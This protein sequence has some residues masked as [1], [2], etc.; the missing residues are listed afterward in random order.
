MTQFLFA[1]AINLPLVFRLTGRSYEAA[2]ICAGIGGIAHGS[3]PTTTVNMTA[4][5]QQYGPSMR[6]YLIVLLISTLFLD[7]VN[8]LLIPF[9]MPMLQ[10]RLSRHW[11]GRRCFAGADRGAGCQGSLLLLVLP[12][13]LYSCIGEQLPVSF[14][15]RIAGCKQR[16]A[17]ED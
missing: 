3:T 16:V 11:S 1:P 9:F 6:A 17:I 2:V 13:C 7:L 12:V 14:H 10:W 8:T 15:V 5:T 4:V